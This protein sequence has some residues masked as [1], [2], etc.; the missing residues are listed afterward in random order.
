[1]QQEAGALK[2]AVALMSRLAVDHPATYYGLRAREW[3]EANDAK[4]LQAVLAKI[5]VA[6]SGA[7][8]WPLDA[9]VLA[10]DP[11]FLAGVEKRGGAGP[12]PLR[13]LVYLLSTA[14]DARAAHA[15]ARTSLRRDLSGAVVVSARPVWEVAYPN[16]FRPLIEKYCG[17]S[18]VDPDLLQALMRE[19]SALDPRA[20]SWAGA[21]GLTQLMPS[22]ARA[23]ASS[24]KIRRPTPAK[25][26]D[27][28][29]NIRLG[30]AHLGQLLKRYNGNASLALASYN[31]GS[32]AVDRWRAGKESQPLDAWVEEIP[33]S[34]TR[35]Y[36]KRV[37]RSYNTYRLLYRKTAVAPPEVSAAP[38][39]TAP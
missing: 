2:E 29:L 12:E 33:L 26:L 36:V 28:E 15:V 6:E 9:G 25:L 18:G 11:H 1:M 24:L 37:L 31:A 38:G 22:T 23:V 30:A 27:P 13:L 17:Q 14:G 4:A 34:E 16:A 39:A 20:L 3:L 10:A 5:Q 19:E 8:A 32:S 21:L 35:G 7:P